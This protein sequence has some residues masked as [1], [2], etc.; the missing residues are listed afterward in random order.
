MFYCMGEE[1]GDVLSSTNITEAN[2]KKYGQVVKKF[3]DFF[4]V[5]RNTVFE[6]AKFNQHNQ[7]EGKSVEQHLN[8]SLM[9]TPLKH[10]FLELFRCVQKLE[11]LSHHLF[12]FVTP[13]TEL[14]REM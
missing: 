11:L 7:M 6:R 5:R 3:D 2:R 4:K 10:L 13:V 1:A 14:K 12:D 8:L 9:I